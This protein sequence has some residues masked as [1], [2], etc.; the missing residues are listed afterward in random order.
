M[1]KK[2]LALK[3]LLAVLVIAI[4]VLIVVELKL[5]GNIDDGDNGLATA[6]SAFFITLINLF[7]DFFMVIGG[8]LLIVATIM[9][10]AAK[11]KTSATI[12]ALVVLCLLLLPVGLSSYLNISALYKTIIVPIAAVA[13]LVTDI[14]CIVLCSMVIHDEKKKK[15]GS[16]DY[17]KSDTLIQDNN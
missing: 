16:S 12:F 3:I 5:I 11:K 10:F 7:I 15:K 2:L 17:N 9:L 1:N 8:V 4:T 6:L 14:A 13:A